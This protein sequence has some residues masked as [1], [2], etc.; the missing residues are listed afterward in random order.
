MAS[1]PRAIAWAKIVVRTSFLL[2]SQ[3]TPSTE[4]EEPR[5]PPSYSF[6]I[7]RP[8][9]LVEMRFVAHRRDAAKPTGSH[10]G[11]TRANVQYCGDRSIESRSGPNLRSPQIRTPARPSSRQ[12]RGARDIGHR[13][14][15]AREPV[16]RPHSV[17]PRLETS[18]IS[19]PCSFRRVEH[20]DPHSGPS[21]TLQIKQMNALD[22]PGIAETFRGL[23][24]W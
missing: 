13:R 12:R 11:S 22:L 17:Q 23:A 2:E 5:L 21:L 4:R 16:M 19:F 3:R 7:H 10:P 1:P 15:T 14:A 6:C 18:G 9:I 24:N 20:G 8:G